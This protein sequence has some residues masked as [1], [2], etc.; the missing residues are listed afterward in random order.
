MNFIYQILFW[1][2]GYDSAK[3]T[4]ESQSLSWFWESKTWKYIILRLTLVFLNFIFRLSST[5][6]Q[7]FLDHSL[8]LRIHNIGSWWL[9]SYEMKKIDWLR[10]RETSLFLSGPTFVFF[11][12]RPLLSNM[13]NSPK[14]KVQIQ[15]K[16]AFYHSR[17]HIKKIM[18]IEIHTS[19]TRSCLDWAKDFLELPLWMNE[20]ERDERSLN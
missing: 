8:S 6:N 12:L 5:Q 15:R 13:M 18:W 17:F 3:K 20:R 9:K 10:I 19:T 4:T 11:L 14:I 2:H 1:I 7:D 16:I